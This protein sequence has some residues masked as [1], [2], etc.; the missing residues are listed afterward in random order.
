MTPRVL[1]ANAELEVRHVPAAD[2]SRHVVTFDRYHDDRTLVRPGFGE[3]FFLRHG[4]TATHVLTRDNDWFQYP[5]LAD[6]FDAIRLAT[7]GAAHVMAYGSSMG[8][9]AAVRFAGAVGASRA[10]A[11]SP[12]Y[13]IDPCKM[14]SEDRWGQDMRR[15]RYL[16]EVDG[17]IAGG[18]APVVAYD[19]WC[20]DGA[21]ADRIAADIPVVRLR[22]PFADHSVAAYL[23]QAGVLTGLVMQTLDGTLDLAAAERAIRQARRGVPTYYC[24]LAARQP[25]WRPNLGVALAEQAVRVAPGLPEPHHALALRLSAAGR[26]AEAVA[27]HRRVAELDRNPAFLIHLSFDLGRAGDHAGALAVAHE[28]LQGL[29]TYVGIRSWLAE[30]HQVQG[31]LAGALAYAEQ[32]LALDPESGHCQGKVAELHAALQPPPPEP[33]PPPPPPRVL[34]HSAEVLV[35]HVPAAD[36]SRHVVTFDCHHD[37]RS[38]D[39]P[40]F[41]EVFLRDRGITAT[42]VLTRD[43]DWFQHPEMA[44]ATAAIRA[45]TAGAAAVLAYG[46]SMG[47]YAAVRFADAVGAGRALAL[48]P[49]YSIDPAKMPFERRWGQDRRR[50]RFLPGIDGPI[51]SAVRPVVAY[52]PHGPDLRH[53]DRIAAD[54]PIIRLAVPHGGHP[55]GTLLSEAGLLTGLVMQALEGTLDPAGTVQAI[56]ARR[57]SLSAYFGALASRQP[58][59]RPR[60]AVALAERA[61]QLAPERAD[62]HHALGLRL[63]AAGRLAEAV[64]AHEQAAAMERHPGYLMDFSRALHAAGDTPAALAVADEVRAAWP[65]HGG[66]HHWMSDLLRAQGDLAGALHFARQAVGFDRDNEL[67]R[68][69]AAMLQAKLRPWSPGSAARFAWL[70]GL[71]LLRGDQA[72]PGGGVLAAPGPAPGA[73]GLGGRR[74]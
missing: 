16:P 32:A 28:V 2:A 59:S 43:N 13:S 26:F 54:T 48:S 51:R 38:L 30:L 27:A 42:H 12:Q 62:T 64:A 18:V 7:A 10:L 35:R 1:F 8:G 60:L 41:G 55:V 20:A 69:T 66:V 67:Y 21:H 31:D 23:S 57:R 22:V 73:G 33:P 9:Y 65:R 14:P 71:R 45:V 34:F 58:V 36:A 40:G 25:A 29:P 4:V 53:A 56:R 3:D 47:G 11:L 37:G 44:E 70:R 15:L 61:V 63:S 52:D 50:V 49:Q 74:P 46:S 24:G 17:P 72:M 39:R 19:P 68:R 5:W 6:A